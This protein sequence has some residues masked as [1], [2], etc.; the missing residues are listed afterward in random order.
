MAVR[1]GL[2]RLLPGRL[3]GVS[4]D[5]AGR[6]ALRLALQTREQHIRR[7][8]ATSN[9]CTA[10]VLLAVMAGMYAVWHGPDGLRRIAQH[11]HDSA[12]AV[13]A[14]AARRGPR[15]GDHARSSTPSPSACP[16][17]T[18]WSR[19][20]WPTGSTCAGS[21]PA[22]S[23]SP[24]TRPPAARTCEAVARALGRP[25]ARRR[26]PR[27]ACPRT[28]SAPAPFC[29]NEVFSRYRSETGLLRYLRRLSDA[30][31][32]L[33]R[34]MIPL[35]SCTMKLNATTEMESVTWSEF[36]DLHPFAP[37]DQAEGTRQVVADLETWLAEVTGYDAVS[38]QPNSGAQGE[39]AGLLAIRGLPPRQ[40]RPGPRRLPHPLQR[41]R[42]QRRERRHGR[43]AGRRRGL[44]RGR[45]RRRRRPARQDRDPPGRPGR[46]DDHLPVDPRGVRGDRHRDLRRRA[47]GRRPGLP[48]RRQPQRARR[49]GPAGQVRRRRQP[50][51]PAQDVL[52]PPRRRRPRRRPDR[53]PRAPARV[54][55]RAPAGADAGRQRRGPGVRG[56]VRLGRHPHHPVDLRADDGRRG[57]DRGHHPGDRGGQLRRRPA[58]RALGRPLHRAQRHRGARVHPRRPPGRQ[59]RRRDRRRHRQAPRRPRLPR[60]DHELAG[61]GDA[62][63][64]ADRERGPGRAR[65]VLRRHDR[66]PRGDR[67]GR[68]GGV[69]R[70]RSRRCAG[71][72][73]PPRTSPRTGTGPT[74]AGSASTRPVVARQVL[75]AGRPDRRRLGRP[76]PRLLL[77]AG[78]RLRRGRGGRRGRHRRP[79]RPAGAGPADRA[80]V[81]AAGR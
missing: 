61:R 68:G 45:Q 24:P 81:E 38:M 13:A 44:R 7:E 21:T 75:A 29:T 52:H 3:V 60:P 17:P 62:D 30:D 10:Q 79:R 42:H 32:A 23:A 43:H 65:P 53:R 1:D 73:T 77:P 25:G 26:R 14:A 46:A 8:K 48:R 2:Q 50:P 28:C 19:R 49:P 74:S 57:P 71:P 5:A 63:G 11:A 22:G 41:P 56:A 70:W 40:R 36:A 18:P 34:G 66:H 64:G 20:R 69:G 37:V 78:E 33:D 15:G 58:A 76:Q 6:P 27:P 47:R 16:T 59:E 54:P 55:A 35:G 12:A 39:L 67:P 31:F 4:K 80:L 51:Q 72:R 9:I